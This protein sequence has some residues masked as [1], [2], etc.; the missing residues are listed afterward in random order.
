LEAT[1]RYEESIVKQL[2]KEGCRWFYV[3]GF[4]E[5]E[6]KPVFVVVTMSGAVAKPVLSKK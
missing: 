6:R 5:K 2:P 4:R 1:N 3:V